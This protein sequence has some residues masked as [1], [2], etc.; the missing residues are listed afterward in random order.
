VLT[1]LG[2]TGRTSEAQFSRQFLALF[3]RRLLCK[4]AE[5]NSVFNAKINAAVNSEIFP[6]AQ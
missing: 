5:I 3:S 2:R 1:V 6:R 4:E